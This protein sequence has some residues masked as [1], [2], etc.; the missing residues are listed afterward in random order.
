MLLL[1]ACIYL[2]LILGAITTLYPFLIMIGS[3]VTSDYDEDQYRV[4]PGYLLSER[5]LFAKFA[6]DKYNGDLTAIN[7]AY[8]TD[9]IKMQSITQPPMYH[10]GLPLQS[11]DRW[12]SF[13]KQLPI[14][15][16]VAGFRG[17]PGQY[18]PDPLNA[19]YQAWLRLRFHDNIRLLDQTYTEEDVSFLSVLPPAE[20]PTQRISFTVESQKTQD[21]NQFKQS[22]SASQLTPVLCDPLFDT[23]LHDEVYN[24]K[25]DLL[26]TAWGTNYADFARIPLSARVP[27]QSTQAKDW[28]AFVRTKLPLI[29]LR[30]DLPKGVSLMQAAQLNHLP[31]GPALAA[32]SAKIRTEDPRRLTVLSTENLWSEDQHEVLH[33]TPQREA[34][35]E[36]V[37]QNANSLRWNFLTRNYLFTLNFLLLHGRGI[38]N[39]VVY[40]AGA[41]LIALLVN[42]LCAYALSRF[43][44][45]AGPAI[46]LFLL[47]TMAFPGE[48][49]MIPNFLL[50]KQLGLLNT[51]WAL[52][53]PGAAS[54]FSIFL[55]K[56]FFDSLPKELYE[57]GMIDGASEMTLF[58]T[59]TFPLSKPILAVIALGAFSSAYGAFLFAMIVCQA[60]SHWTLMVWIYEFQALN[61]P[62]YVIM[63]ALVLAALPTLIV[64]LFT[65]KIIMRGII[66]PSF[67]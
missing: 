16:K 12:N 13:L 5:V 22:L 64:F 2:I 65:Q 52:L 55:L 35:W 3:S 44:L 38:W 54:G 9:F 62:Q 53:L 42:P 18:A 25:V 20:R 47:A 39:T 7:A 8:G 31:A 59:V 41:V 6:D 51:F 50:L 28:E 17:S 58:R 40:C 21:W 34:D 24:G 37:Q 10:W 1:K 19:E 4:I 29:Y 56:G 60:Q 36:Y 67:K 49:A 15:Y 33:I 66:L 30:Q 11:V 46:L 32:F 43:K 45:A 57:A 26:N 27:I 23:Y 61:A 48:V 63:S 14:A